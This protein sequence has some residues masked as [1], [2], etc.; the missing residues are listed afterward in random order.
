MR[1]IAFAVTIAFTPAL[2]QQADTTRP[3][4]KPTPLATVNVVDTLGRAEY[5]RQMSR[6]ATKSPTL[7][8]DI[9]QALTPVSREL[10]TDQ[11]MQGMADV[12]RFI[13]GVVAAQGE[14]NR[15]Q[16]SI[17]GNNTTADFFVDGVRD[18]AQYFRDLYNVDRVESIRGSNALAFGRGGGGGVIN[19]VSKE[20]MWTTIREVTVEAGAHDHKRATLD[21]NG[22]DGPTAGRLNAMYQNSGMFRDGVRLRRYGVNPTGRLLIGGSTI[23]S[24][25]YEYFDDYRTADRGIPSFDGAPSPAPLATFFGQRDSSYATARVQNGSLV[26]DRSFGEHF[27]LRNQSRVAVYDKFYQNV[28]AGAVDATGDSVTLQGYNNATLRHNAFNQTDATWLVA[29]GPLR[30]TIAGGVEVGRQHSDNFRNTAFFD[31]ATTTIS[32][33]FAAPTVSTP[34]TFRQRETDADNGVT[35]RTASVYVQ[36]QLELSRHLQLIGGVRL[37]QFRMSYHN[38]RDGSDLSRTDR[39]VSPRGGIV[40]KPAEPLSFYGSVSTSY[41]PSSGDQFSSLNAT[42]STLEPE[43][44]TNREVGAKWD[45]TPRLAIAAALFRLDRTNTSAKDPADPARTIQTGAQRTTGFELSAQG[46]VTR[47]WQVALAHSTLRARIVSATTAAPAGAAVPLVPKNRMSVWN[48]FAF[49]R[50][51]AA[52]LAV[53]HQS[54][55]FAAIDNTVTL[56]AFTHVDGALFLPSF[57]GATPQVNV[58][59]LFNTRYFSSAN[60][61]NNISFGAPRTVRVALRFQAGR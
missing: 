48:R 60:G 53:V 59:N 37:E 43:R 54:R 45:A 4:Q 17:R 40:V 12:V 55:V 27:S 61:N 34:V 42:T 7:L 5:L 36:D 15:D 21:L 33:P 39:M 14:G 1:F 2:A 6:S 57:G 58:E 47:R 26:V 10:I 8:R 51:W 23:V 46:N 38:N 20:A 9:P 44:F 18:D 49:N 41:L 22:H 28:F 32:T 25:S 11:A 16:V 50:D 31:D 29:S 35:A 19:R 3:G 24:A 56:P 13:P 30:H 52:G